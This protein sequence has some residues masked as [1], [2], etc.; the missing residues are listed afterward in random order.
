VSKILDYVEKEKN[1]TDINEEELAQFNAE[2]SENK[3]KI[4]PDLCGVAFYGY[5]IDNKYDKQ[6]SNITGMNW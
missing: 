1:E 2:S 3:F 6:E 4:K 5:Y